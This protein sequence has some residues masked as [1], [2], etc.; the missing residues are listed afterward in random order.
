MEIHP[1][2]MAR[3]KMLEESRVLLFREILSLGTV[4]LFPL[5]N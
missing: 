3:L 4:T 5:K 2:E 1:D